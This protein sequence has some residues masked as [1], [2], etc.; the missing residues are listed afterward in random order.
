MNVFTAAR[1]MQEEEMERRIADLGNE[2]IKSK[3]EIGCRALT[4]ILVE[5]T[6]RTLARNELDLCSETSSSGLEAL[7]TAL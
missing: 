3:H 7:Q 1:R 2:D 6:V 4:T 5:T